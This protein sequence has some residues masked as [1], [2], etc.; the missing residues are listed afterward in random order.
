MLME[1]AAVG[2]LVVLIGVTAIGIVDRFLIGMGLVWTEELGRY[3]L[4]WTSFLSAIV[5]TRRGSHFKVEFL[6]AMLGPVYARLI[7]AFSIVVCLT[8]AWYGAQF[9][10][11]FRNQHSPALGLSMTIVYA[12]GPVGFIG[13]AAYMAR[14]LVGPGSALRPRDRD[15]AEDAQ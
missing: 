8:A 2:L 10:W 14:D 3:L 15:A 7:L 5:A 1:F 4:V 11:F 6:S 12:A 13:M 9:A